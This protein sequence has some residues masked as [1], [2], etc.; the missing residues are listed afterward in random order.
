MLHLVWTCKWCRWQTSLCWWQSSHGW[1]LQP[2]PETSAPGCHGNRSPPPS[3]RWCWSLDPRCCTLENKHKGNKQTNTHRRT[4]T[5]TR[6]NPSLAGKWPQKARRHTYACSRAL[7]WARSEC[8]LWF[9]CVIIQL[10]NLRQR[11]TR[12]WWIIQTD[13]FFCLYYMCNTKHA[14]VQRVAA[15]VLQLISHFKQR[16]KRRKKKTVTP[17]NPTPGLL[18][19]CWCRSDHQMALIFH[20]PNVNLV[21]WIHIH[22]MQC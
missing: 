8:Q 17:P 4:R 21:I 16:L 15:D 3:V 19:L 11:P 20:T 18:Q 1:T 2:P 10:W 9:I 5:N 12:Q 7:A 13:V 6:R 14:C 22:A